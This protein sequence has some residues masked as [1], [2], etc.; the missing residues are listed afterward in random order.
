MSPNIQENNTARKPRPSY[1]LVRNTGE[2]V[3]LIAVDELPP[4]V[5]L[6][7]V[8]RALNLEDTIGMLNLGLQRSSEAFYHVVKEESKTREKGASKSLVE[9]TATTTA[10]TQPVPNRSSTSMNSTYPDPPPNSPAVSPKSTSLATPSTGP[11]TDL[12]TKP[13]IC[14]HWCLHG[15]CK[16]GQQ[17]QH[18]HIMPMTLHGLQQLGLR[19]WPEWYRKRNPGCFVNDSSVGGRGRRGALSETDVRCREKMEVGEQIVRKLRSLEVKGGE[20]GREKKVGGSVVKGRGAVK[21]L[22]VGGN[23]DNVLARRETRNWEDDSESSDGSTVHGG[24]AGD[25]EGREEDIVPRTP[26]AVQTELIEV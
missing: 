4:S 14:R 6:V 17:C 18:R 25:G 3:P 11:R 10:K 12:N 24:N 22:R 26:L 2:V 8:P 21:A 13:Q 20:K 19:D 23:L 15:I 1:F 7:G 9:A 5:S 16:W